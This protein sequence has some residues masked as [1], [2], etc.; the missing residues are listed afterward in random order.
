VACHYAEQVDASAE[1]RQA[2][3]LPMPVAP[4]GVPES[5]EAAPAA[6]TADEAGDIFLDPVPRTWSDDADTP[7]APPPA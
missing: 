1:Q 7:S 4:G 3:G 6:G 2:L 5:T